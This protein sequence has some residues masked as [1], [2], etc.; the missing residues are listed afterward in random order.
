M[1]H[2]FLR[3]GFPGKI[4]LGFV[5][6]LLICLP[7][8]SSS[9][10]S[11]DTLDMVRKFRDQN[12]IKEAYTLLKIYQIRNSKDFNTLWLS[13][14]IS[15]FRKHFKESG[16]FYEEAIRLAPDNLYL[17][18]DYAKMLVNTGKFNPAEK[19][20]K[21]YLQYDPANS[22]AI[23]AMARIS[24]WQ[25]DYRK[26]L[27]ELQMLPASTMK[28]PAILS[29]EKDIRTARSPWL[30]YNEGFL[31]DDQPL[32]VLT[33]QLEAGIY[34]H[35]LSSLHLFMQVPV[36]ITD[37]KTA[38]WIQAGNFAFFPEENVQMDV[39][40][41]VVLFPGNKH[42]D[43]TG[44]FEATRTFIRNLFITV[45]G[46][47]NPYFSTLSSIDSSIIENN[48]S[49][50]TGWNNPETPQGQVSFRIHHYPWDNNLLYSTSTWILSPSFKFSFADFKAGYGYSYNTTRKDHFEP[51]KSLSQILDNYNSSGKIKGIYNP[52]FTPDEQSIHSLLIN[53]KLSPGKIFQLEVNGNFGIYSTARVPYFYLD[54]DNNR[55]LTIVKAFIRDNY[56]PV[57][58]RTATSVRLSDFV[59]IQ[60]EYLYMK[61]YYFS[62][63]YAG[64]GINVNFNHD[65]SKK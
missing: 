24:Y 5:Y 58:I 45:C 9:Q 21:K 16:K 49:I 59:R 65:P 4:F 28:D 56:F 34:L 22:Q 37:N 19:L 13:G 12:K 33:S 41:G 42:A 55:K 60:A 18:L 35:H 51:E 30:S 64:I 48:I 44:K 23:G 32:M 8:R 27:C 10:T 52:Y 20:L 43:W 36:F 31:S 63:H 40:A 26:A 6:S 53:L 14:Q 62:S 57:Q 47:R 1:I 7:V 17:Q 54:F 39:N 3:P 46:E 11:S 38:S 25:K 29:L 50:T 15:Y 2:C 61:T